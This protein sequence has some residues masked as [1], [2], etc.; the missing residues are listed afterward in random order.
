MTV[1]LSAMQKHVVWC[2]MAFFLIAS[3]YKYLNSRR[4]I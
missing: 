4:Q 2:I 3:I 1:R